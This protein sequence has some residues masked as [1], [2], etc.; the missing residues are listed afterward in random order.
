MPCRHIAHILNNYSQE[1]FV[2]SPNCVDLRYHNNYARFVA[3]MTPT[4][5]SSEEMEIRRA[6]IQL[7]KQNRIMLPEAPGQFNSK[8]VVIGKHVFNEH[9]EH[10]TAEIV[11]EEIS[12]LLAQT[13]ESPV[14]LNYSPESVKSAMT[15]HVFGSSFREDS[16]FPDEG[17]DDFNV[18]FDWDPDDEP[19]G[20][21]HER[22]GH[23]IVA[24]ISREMVTV[25]DA[26]SPQTRKKLE[27]EL[28][29]WVHSKRV[30]VNRTLITE[31]PKGKV[32]S[33]KVKTKTRQRVHKKQKK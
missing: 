10:L 11:M 28:K 13:K 26:A 14:C 18:S 6:L 19:D 1:P 8:Q 9:G 20:G 17:E 23:E 16:F 21:N 30:V 4:D 31:Q 2:C 12:A 24:P 3:D 7:R 32:V 15:N 25:F 29:M 27:E 22:S 33:G 5:L